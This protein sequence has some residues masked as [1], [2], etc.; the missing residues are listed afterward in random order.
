MGDGPDHFE[1]GFSHARYPPRDYGGHGDRGDRGHPRD[2]EGQH[3]EG[4]R[5]RGRGFVSDCVFS[6]HFFS[7]R[8]GTDISAL[9]FG[10]KGVAVDRASLL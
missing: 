9:I 10:P 6:A 4:Q 3:M 8:P 5:G 2:F 7:F 1:E